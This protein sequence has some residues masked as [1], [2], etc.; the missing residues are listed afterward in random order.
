MRGLP[1]LRTSPPESNPKFKPL[2]TLSSTHFKSTLRRFRLR[3]VLRVSVSRLIP[4]SS[5]F[6]VLAQV[7][8]STLNTTFLAL[9]ASLELE[10]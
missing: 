10:I 5:N 7:T 3:R 2:Q 9:L 8:I 4:I 1:V 6:H